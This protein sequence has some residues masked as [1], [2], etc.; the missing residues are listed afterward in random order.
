MLHNLRPA[1]GSKR[2]PKRV[3]RGNSSGHGTFS[4]RGAKGQ[5]AR[6]GGR[7]G[8]IKFAVKGMVMRMP[9]RR[10]FTS[11]HIK[12]A[13]VDLTRLLKVFSESQNIT[14]A[15]M[16]KF[17]L[18]STIRYGVKVIGQAT[19]TKPVTIQAHGFSQAAASA[20]TRAGGQ[21]IKIKLG[22]N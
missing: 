1:P 10:G 22:K 8:L 21:A 5:K 12:M 13:S 4:T 20:I 7:R 14:P 18:V 16:V 15:Q 3:G 6:A 9:K 11:P 19:I 17:N 2:Q